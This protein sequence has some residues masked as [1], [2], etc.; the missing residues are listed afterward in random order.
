MALLA[1]ALASPCA[2]CGESNGLYPA[3]GQVMYQ[4]EPASGAILYF[5]RVGPDASG[6]E[7]ALGQVGSDGWY[8][9]E[10]GDK[11]SG[12]S[13]GQYA[14]L[15]EWRQGPLRTRRVETA[16]SVGKAVAREGKPLLIADDRLKGRYFDV[17]HPR[18]TVEI[19]AEKNK[20]SVIEL[21]D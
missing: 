17:T 14:V 8:Y 5:H 11:G 6:G 16:K 13:P 4:G 7:A 3:Y 19:K 1:C 18:V 2:G 20:L 12:I 10:S 21:T 15:I 9:L